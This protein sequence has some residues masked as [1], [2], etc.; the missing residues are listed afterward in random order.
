[1]MGYIDKDNLLN[2]ACHH[3]SLTPLVAKVVVVWNDGQDALSI[4]T[5]PCSQ[6]PYAKNIVIRNMQYNTLL[7]RYIIYPDVDTAAAIL[8]DD[9]WMVPGKAAL[10]AILEHWKRAPDQLV[11]LQRICISD[12]DPHW[13]SQPASCFGWVNTGS[14][15][16]VHRRYLRQY[17]TQQ[18][19]EI[20]EHIFTSRP[21]CEDMALGFLVMNISQKPIHELPE[22]DLVRAVQRRSP[23]ISKDTPHFA[24]K[25]CACLAKFAASYGQC[26]LETCH[27]PRQAKTTDTRRGGQA[28][29]AP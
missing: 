12:R 26:P 4:H 25:R 18:P 13:H 15:N 2:S 10:Q 22:G 24:E 3:A 8:I 29:S 6:E 27:G 17:F 23:S 11:T 5:A 16:V 14:L 21:T 20:L 28:H 19:R 9:D 7:N 1:M